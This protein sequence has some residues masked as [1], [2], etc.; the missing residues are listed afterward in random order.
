MDCAV[1][2]IGRD[3]SVAD[4]NGRGDGIGRLMCSATWMGKQ[5][6][7]GL[8][9]T[10]ILLVSSAGLQN[11]RPRS[12]PQHRASQEGVAIPSCA[13][14]KTRPSCFK[15]S[16]PSIAAVAPPWEFFKIS[17]QHRAGLVAGL[18]RCPDDSVDSYRGRRSGD[19]VFD[20]RRRCKEVASSD[21]QTLTRHSL[22]GNT[23]SVQ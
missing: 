6:A 20:A 17:T 5:A 16:E 3:S 12:G 1:C 13:A 10:A 4:N 11:G 2:A 18:P 7:S 15:V 21:T 22:H 19:D 9:A 8:D 14:S 23:G